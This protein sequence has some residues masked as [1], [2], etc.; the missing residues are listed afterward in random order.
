VSVESLAQSVA[1]RSTVANQRLDQDLLNKVAKK[2]DK[3]SLPAVRNRV[4]KLASKLGI[5]SEAA[6]VVLARDLKLG[7]NKALRNLTAD[8]RAEF[9]STSVPPA[10]IGRVASSEPTAPKIISDQKVIREAVARLFTDPDMKQRVSDLVTAR[11]HYDRPISEAT[12]ILEIRI[13]DK[14]PA[15]KKNLVGLRLVSAT[16]DQ[17]YAKSHAK[18]G[19]DPKEH[20]GYVLQIRG[21]VSAFRNPTHHKIIDTFNQSDALSICAYINLLIKIVESADNGN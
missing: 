17:E 7:H 8:Q 4:S 5:S 11:K 6:L 2:T 21:V 20:E 16:F 9:R 18:I 19:H 14:A 13:R 3:D 1:Q 10:R 12:K 15:D